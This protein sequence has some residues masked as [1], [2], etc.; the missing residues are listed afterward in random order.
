[1][2]KYPQTHINWSRCPNWGD[3]RHQLRQLFPDAVF[4]G[5]YADLSISPDEA[6]AA[7]ENAGFA[8]HW[9]N[10]HDHND[11]RIA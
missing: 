2:M 11:L 8:I 3:V 9:Q 7:L 5:N 6:K 4:G 10:P 1:M